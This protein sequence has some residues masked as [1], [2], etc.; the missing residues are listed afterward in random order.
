MHA[1]SDVRFIITQRKILSIKRK[2]DDA[3]WIV[4]E[5]KPTSFSYKEKS[6]KMGNIEKCLYIIENEWRWEQ[7]TQSTNRFMLKKD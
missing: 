7:K 6:K 2:S 1:E 4:F 5:I 3:S